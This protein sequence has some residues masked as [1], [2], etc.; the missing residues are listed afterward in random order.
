MDTKSEIVQALQKHEAEIRQFG[1]QK[2]GIFGSFSRDTA[3]KESDIDFVVI[4]EPGKKN[5][6][7]YIDLVFFLEDLSS[8]NADVL[9]PESMSPYL[10]PHILEELEYVI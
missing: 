2:L 4:F 8:R 7:R 1:V 5:F 10:K 6:S 3:N 9:T